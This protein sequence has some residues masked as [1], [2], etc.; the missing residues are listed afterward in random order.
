[1]K[2]VYE[3]LRMVCRNYRDNQVIAYNFIK[4]FV[5]D[6]FTDSGAE[7][8]FSEIFRNNYSLLC[9]IANELKELHGRNL[10]NTIFSK[11]ITSFS[12]EKNLVYW[13]RI[14]K[15]FDLLE[16]LIHYRD[17]TIDINQRLIST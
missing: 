12:S 8:L 9:K 3:I 14:T 16:V 6:I 5:E 10:I 7:E 17:A 15:L 4:C 1:M 2:N 11:I 13:T